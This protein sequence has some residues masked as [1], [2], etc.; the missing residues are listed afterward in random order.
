MKRVPQFSDKLSWGGI[1]WTTR[2]AGG[3][4]LSP[5]VSPCP[6]MSNTPTSGSHSSLW[7]EGIGRAYVERE[8]T[9]GWAARGNSLLGRLDLAAQLDLFPLFL[10]YFLFLFFSTY[11]KFKFEFKQC[12]KLV[13]LF[14]C[15]LWSGH[16]GH[17]LFIYEFTVYFIVF[18]LP[19][20]LFF[21]YFSFSN[22]QV[23]H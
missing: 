20:F 7:A 6:R 13:L 18:F 19:S 21:D 1:R 12:C 23:T 8:W 2:L 4:H 9:E 10:L 22:I 15:I 5:Q 14:V 3:T 16:Y 17:N 11:S